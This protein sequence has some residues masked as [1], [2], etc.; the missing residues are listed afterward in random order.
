M[1]PATRRKVI[2]GNWKMNTTA[3]EAGRLARAIVCGGF[4]DDQVVVAICPPFPYQSFSQM[5]IAQVVRGQLADLR[6]DHRACDSRRATSV[7]GPKLAQEPRFH[8]R[9]SPHPPAFGRRPLPCG[10]RFSDRS[11]SI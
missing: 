6:G 8:A 1:T 7:V 10:A 5:A 11:A 2:I 3:T 9:S 4:R